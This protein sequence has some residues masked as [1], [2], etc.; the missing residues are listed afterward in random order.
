MAALDQWKHK[1]DFESFT[2]AL[3]ADTVI[4]G[5]LIDIWHRVAACFIGSDSCLVFTPDGVDWNGNQ[6]DGSSCRGQ[7]NLS[8]VFLAF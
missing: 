7:M 6:G 8:E 5:P 4:T 1:P 2:E 3:Q